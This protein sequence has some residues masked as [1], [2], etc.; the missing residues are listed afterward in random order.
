MYD[1]RSSALVTLSSSR[2][3]AIACDL[4]FRPSIAFIRSRIHALVLWMMTVTAGTGVEC[5]DGFTA[6]LWAA[7]SGN[8]EL[9][10]W[11][12][13]EKRVDVSSQ[14]N[15]VPQPAV[16]SWAGTSTQFTTPPIQ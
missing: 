8:M 5:Q 15:K 3:C 16:M 10:R 11:I 4:V 9:L 7:W 13:E 14:R 2:V 1:A 12:V 6:L